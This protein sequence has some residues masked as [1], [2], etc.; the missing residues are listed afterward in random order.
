[1]QRGPQIAHELDVKRPVQAELADQFQPLRL[2]VVLAEND[3]HRVADVGEQR[4]R[5]QPDDQQHRNGLQ[6]PGSDKSEHSRM[7]RIFLGPF[8]P[9]PFKPGCSRRCH[10]PEYS[11]SL[12]HSS[13]S[14]KPTP[15]STGPRKIPSSPKASTPPS[16]PRMVSKNGK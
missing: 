12:P 4:E 2:G 10:G 14:V 5:D 9:G 6:Q 16:T 1:M 8:K 13:S 3:R 7:S 11:S 15:R